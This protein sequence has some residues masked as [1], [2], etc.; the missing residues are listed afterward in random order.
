MLLGR[1]KM[2]NILMTQEMMIFKMKK[3]M[4]RKKERNK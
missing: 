2:L 3:S 4:K 1:K